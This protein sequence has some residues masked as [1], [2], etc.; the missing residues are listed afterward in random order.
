MSEGDKK[1]RLRRLA[2]SIRDRLDAHPKGDYRSTIRLDDDRYSRTASSHLRGLDEEL[3]REIDEL[4]GEI[5]RDSGRDSTKR[6]AMALAYAALR[7][8]EINY[9]RARDIV[10]E[11]FGE[12][13]G[14]VK[15]AY[16]AYRKWADEGATGSR[17]DI[18]ASLKKL[19]QSHTPENVVKLVRDGFHRSPFG[20]YTFSLPQFG[21][22][23]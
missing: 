22:V 15:S 2:N 4:L 11:E 5:L 6:R 7:A 19:G 12:P 8:D 20:G 1:T 23:F 14:K 18:E 16:T 17:S 10:G 3:F 21:G 13:S 9:L